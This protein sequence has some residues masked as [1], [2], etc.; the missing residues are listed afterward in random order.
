ML[1]SSGHGCV[2]STESGGGSSAPGVVVQCCILA[3]LLIAYRVSFSAR[4]MA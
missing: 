1:G 2:G 4:C 3:V